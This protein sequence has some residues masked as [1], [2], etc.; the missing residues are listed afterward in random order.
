MGFCDLSISGSDYASD[1]VG[2]LEKSIIDCLEAELSEMANEY[3]T[4]GIENVA[5]I[6]DEIII[7]SDYWCDHGYYLKPFAARAAIKLEELIENYKKAD[8]GNWSNKERHISDCKNLA[9]RLD[10][11]INF[12]EN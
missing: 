2:V 10:Y 8:I 12:S 3:N 9:K 7:P 11:F 1:A 5:M 6:F 4:N